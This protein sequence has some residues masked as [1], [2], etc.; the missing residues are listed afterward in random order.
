MGAVVHLKGRLAGQYLVAD[1]TL[2][3][4]RQPTVTAIDQGLQLGHLVGLVNLDEGLPGVVCAAGPGQEGVV[5]MGILTE[6][7]AGRQEER[8]MTALV[9]YQR[10]GAE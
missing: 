10:R 1:D 6:V 9:T 5:D 7:Q 4:I 8:L 2:I 3:W